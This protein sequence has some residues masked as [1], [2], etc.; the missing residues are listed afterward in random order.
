MP[1]R[2]PDRWATRPTVRSVALA[3]LGFSLSGC[4]DAESAEPLR[5]DTVVTCDIIISAKAAGVVA[6]VSTIEVKSQASGEITEVA[7]NE[8]DEVRRG[9]LLVRVDPRIPSNAVTQAEADSVVARAALEN[10]ESRFD[11]ARQ[12]FEQQALTE[13]EFESARLAQATA[14]ADLIR[15]QRALEDARIA[16]VQTEVRAPSAGI[17]L[18]RAVA[19]GSVIASASRDVGGGAVLIRM[20]ALD[21]VEVRALVD[22]RDIGQIRAGLPVSLTV[23][24]FPSRPFSG[25]VLRVGAEAVVEQNV[26]TFPVL[27]RIPNRDG[28]LKPGMNAEVEIYI[29]RETGVVAVP[30][31]ALRDPAELDAAAAMLGLSPDSL[32]VELRGARGRLVVFK[33]DSTGVRVVPVR[34]GLTDYDYSMVHEGL[35]PGDSVLILPT[36]G[37]LADQARRSEWVQ[38]RVGGGPLGGN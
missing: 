33:L 23:A 7:V 9:Q 3:L 32:R 28:L 13:E 21:T 36:E 30:N 35:A 4:T 25:E 27:V 29:G 24:S 8:G 5:V 1:Y 16:F 11:R 38:R 26:T 14:N 18:S 37:L 19:V 2:P 10:A 15:A 17:I 20:A 31:S 34:T 12:L 6:P 22:E